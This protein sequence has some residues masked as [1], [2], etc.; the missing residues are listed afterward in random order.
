M[1]L[2]GTVAGG[3]V[4]LYLAVLSTAFAGSRDDLREPFRGMP[5]AV[6]LLYMIAQLEDSVGDVARKR[7]G[8]FQRK[9]QVEP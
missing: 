5:G 7:G 9:V 4:D 3:G 2:D 6:H 1:R 8:C